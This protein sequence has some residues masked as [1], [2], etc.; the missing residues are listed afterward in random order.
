MECEMENCTHNATIINYS[1]T[2]YFTLTHGFGGMNI[3]MCCYVKEIENGLKIL[4]KNYN[5]QKVKLDK[6]GCK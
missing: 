6:G 3:C 5:K 2:P 1:R 4:Q